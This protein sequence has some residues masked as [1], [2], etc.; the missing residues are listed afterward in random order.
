MTLMEHVERYVTFKKALGLKFKE[1]E[2]LLRRYA[3][4][5][6]AHGDRFVVSSRVLDW[7][8]KTFSSSRA[9][10]RLHTV[11]G[12]AVS[13]HAEDERHE[14]PPRDYFGKCRSRRRTPMIL[15]L[16]Q[17]R[18]IMEATLSL[19]PA[20][21]MTPVTFHYL[22]GLMA[23]TGLRRSEATNLLL[24]DVTSD[25]LLIRNTKF[26]KSRQLPLD[27]SV[28]H[29][30]DQYLAI[31]MRSGGLDEHL[32]VLSSAKPVKPAY[33]THVFIELARKAGVRGGPGEP[34]P[35]LYDL[36]HTF[37]TRAL[38]RIESSDRKDVGR[39]MLALSTYLG[40]SNIE[41]TYWYLE[42]TPVLL[43]QIAVATELRHTGRSN[44]D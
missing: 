19:P 35:R 17:I 44:D 8:G 9:P 22:V 3:T 37:A 30:L 40:H 42:A 26:G 38:E 15:S 7:V 14:M 32:F 1:Q 18:L 39:H 20:G 34:G 24:T 25:G 27:D 21:S 11:C 29:A 4:Y 36:R 31:R 12:F 23:T 33:L 6:E 10:R 41:N 2:Q 13:L 5:A 28:R 16:A 43:R